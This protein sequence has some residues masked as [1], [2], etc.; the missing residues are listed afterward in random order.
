MRNKIYTL[1]N[2]I[3]ILVGSVWFFV[4]FKDTKKLFLD[5]NNLI[6]PILIITVIM[7]Y[8][9]KSF[10]LYF[11]MYG[12]NISFEQFIKTYIRV[13]PISI[14]LPFK[15]GELFRIYCYGNQ[16][17]NY[18]QGGIIILLDRFMDTAALITMMVFT[19]IFTKSSPTY[20]V[21]FLFCSMLLL[22]ALYFLFPGMHYFWRKFLLRSNASKNKLWI[23]KTLVYCNNVYDEIAKVVKGRGIILYF[24]SLV[25]WML[26]I[27]SLAITTNMVSSNTSMKISEYITSA[28]TGHVTIEMRRFIFIS[29]IILLDIYVLL[30][31]IKLFHMKRGI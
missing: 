22:S 20:L 24:L 10:R 29:V 4:Y 12:V 8:V 25:A 17:N 1:T 15:A 7:V 23:L 31:I 18:L 6:L 13:T 5:N 30:W 2:L 26:E 19:L 14:I 21:Y 16:I 9:I 11:A 28:M 3:V 27:G